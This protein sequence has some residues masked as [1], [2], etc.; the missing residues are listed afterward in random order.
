MLKIFVNTWGNYNVNGTDGGEWIELPMGYAEL[1]EKLEAIAEAMNDDDPE[2]FINDYEWTEDVDL[3][4]VGEMDD[5]EEWNNRCTDAEALEDYELVE[6]QAAMEAW[7]Y[8]FIEAWD[9]QQAGYFT[10]WEGATLEEVA[11]ELVEDC[12]FDRNTPDIF[13]QYFDYEAFA[14]DLCFDGYEETSFGVILDN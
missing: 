4:A 5:I 13:R 9:R 7:G 11:E 6:I 1:T 8:D 12:Y 14:R 2:F 10:F 3:G